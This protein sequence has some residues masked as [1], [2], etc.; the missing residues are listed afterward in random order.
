M[1][2]VNTLHKSSSTLVGTSMAGLMMH[3]N[4]VYTWPDGA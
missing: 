1:V 4:G 3:G 2:M